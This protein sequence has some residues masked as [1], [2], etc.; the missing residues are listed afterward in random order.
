MQ[1][2]NIF[3]INT[4]VS[5]RLRCMKSIAKDLAKDP[6]QRPLP[7]GCAFQRRNHKLKLQND[8]RHYRNFENPRLDAATI[9]LQSSTSRGLQK[10]FIFVYKPGAK[11]VAMDNGGLA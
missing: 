6:I 7:M 10:D 9:S 1:E 4:L 11:I 2:A 8:V 5:N 3:C